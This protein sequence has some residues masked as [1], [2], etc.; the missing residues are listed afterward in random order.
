MKDNLKTGFGSLANTD[1]S[2]PS[3]YNK[4]KWNDT[5]HLILG[6]P[7]ARDNQIIKEN[8]IE[9]MA[10]NAIDSFPKIRPVKHIPITCW[11]EITLADILSERVP[12]INDEIIKNSG[13]K[14]YLVTLIGKGK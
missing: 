6:Q 5:I 14:T 7:K 12:V 4:F 11:S 9:K 1:G 3:L 13:E 10:R 8:W 2:V